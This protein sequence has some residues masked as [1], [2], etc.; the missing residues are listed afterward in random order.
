MAGVPHK[1]VSQKIA[2]EFSDI[3]ICGAQLRRYEYS[4]FKIKRNSLNIELKKCNSIEKG[5]ISL[6]DKSLNIKYGINGT[7]KSTISKA[8]E[9]YVTDKKNSSNE[10]SKLKPF[11][12]RDN[13]NENNPE[14]S[15][16]D[17]VES[18]AI[19]SEDYINQYVFQP[20]ELLKNSFDI[21]INNEAYQS[22]MEDINQLIKEI[23]K[24]FEDNEDIDIMINNLNERATCRLSGIS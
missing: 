5:Q 22:G 12:Y 13:P 9:Y 6:V 21:L 14:V 23:S 2:S 20:N 3:L 4:K 16:L 18:I 10:L 7:G 1:G 15:G 8:I 19:F 24:T 11:K 17:S